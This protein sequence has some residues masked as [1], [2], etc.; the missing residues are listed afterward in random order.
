M[1][2]SYQATELQRQ[3]CLQLHDMEDRQK[4]GRKGTSTEN[5]LEMRVVGIDFNPGPDAEDRLRRVF[6]ILLKQAVG[7]E[8]DAPAEE[9]AEEGE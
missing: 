2:E 6:T 3:F 4:Y 8:Q 9:D 7:G 1:D 5:T